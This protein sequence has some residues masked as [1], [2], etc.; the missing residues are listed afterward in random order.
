MKIDKQKMLTVVLPVILI[1]LVLIIGAVNIFGGIKPA[2]DTIT[3]EAGQELVPDA[4]VL[5]K[6]DE[7]TA[8]K[9]TFDTSKVDVNKAGTYELTADYK[10]HTYRFKVEVEDTTAPSVEFTHRYVFTNDVKNADLES[11]IDA[12]YDASEYTMELVRFEKNGTLNVMDEKALNV[13]TKSIPIPCDEEE[14]LTLGTEDIPEEQGIYRSVLALKDAYDN[15]CYEEVYVILDTTGAYIDDVEDIEVTAAKDKLAEKPELDMSRYNITDNADGVIAASDIQCE[16]KQEDE[17]AHTWIATIS[18]TD[19]AGNESYISHLVTVKEESKNQTPDN[20]GSGNNDSNDANNSNTV[21]GTAGNG[22]TNAGQTN[23]TQTGNNDKP[24]R[25]DKEYDPADTNKDG[26]V[27][28]DE[29]YA[30]ISPSEQTLIDAG[31]GNVVLLPTGNYGVLVHL[32]EFD[33]YIGHDLLRDYLVELD[34]EGHIGGYVIRYDN[35]WACW[36][37][38]ELHELIGPD[39]LEYWED[40]DAYYDEKTGLWYDSYEDYINGNGYY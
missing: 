14:M 16:L 34:L 21:N 25:D 13:L 27:D 10:M 9:V 40:N 31:Y 22:N 26:V 8:A 2:T 17:A 35:D 20:E 11:M 33:A 28:G 32:D 36:I 38:R 4:V 7:K 3:H 37:A 5:F 29:A 30:Y 18:Y 6:I 23:G 24:S 12:V 15:A 1:V 39:D 19:R